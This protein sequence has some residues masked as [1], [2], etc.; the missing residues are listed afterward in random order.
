M[1]SNVQELISDATPSTRKIEIIEQMTAQ[2]LCA[3]LGTEEVPGEL[4]Y[5]LDEMTIKRF[6]RLGSEGMSSTS[7]EG[8]SMTFD[9]KDLEPFKDDLDAWV[10]K[11]K[12][13]N[14]KGWVLFNA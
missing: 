11:N 1:S 13:A 6:N 7:Q 9:D 10:D 5:I 12:P 4:A 8:L 2:R 14:K 3:Y